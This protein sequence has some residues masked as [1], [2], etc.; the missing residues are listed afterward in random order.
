MFVHNMQQVACSSADGRQLLESSKTALDKGKL[1]D[2]VN[3]GT[4]V[5][6]FTKQSIF[7]NIF[8]CHL[9]FNHYSNGWMQAL[10]KLI[11][12]CGPYHRMTAGAYSLLAVVLYHT[13]DFNQVYRYSFGC[14]IIHITAKYI[15]KVQHIAIF[16]ASF[17]K[18]I[19][20]SS[21]QRKIPMHCVS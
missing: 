1:E 18:N 11:T 3:Y 8:G 15:R 19:K 7:L 10:A 16:Q 12:V 17:M 2:A 20:H 9:F 13:G 6:S 14:R 5:S 21:Q 4:K